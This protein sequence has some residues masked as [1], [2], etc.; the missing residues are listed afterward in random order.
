MRQC[1]NQSLWNAV[2]EGGITSAEHKID[3]AM[4]T[5]GASRFLGKWGGLTSAIWKMEHW[6]LLATHFAGPPS[7]SSKAVNL[8]QL[9]NFQILPWVAACGLGWVADVKKVANCGW[10]ICSAKRWSVAWHDKRAE[11][12]QQGNCE[13]GEPRQIVQRNCS[14]CFTAQLQHW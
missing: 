7:F 11:K 9:G 13:E 1:W 5:S 6:W 8:F 10:Q 14:C 3:G 4:S 12:E 2:S